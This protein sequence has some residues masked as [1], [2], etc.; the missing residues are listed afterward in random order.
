MNEHPTAFPAY[1]H[2]DRFHTARTVGLAVAGSVLV[3]VPRPEAVG[4]VVAVCR[5]GRVE[6]DVY[7]AVRTAKRTCEYQGVRPFGAEVRVAVNMASL[8][9][10][11]T[12][13]RLT[14]Q[15]APRASV[16]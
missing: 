5:A 11:W 12:L 7:T 2:R 1:G 15:Q 10:V 16:N 8:L 13:V 4:A 3:E 14:A 9:S 6:R